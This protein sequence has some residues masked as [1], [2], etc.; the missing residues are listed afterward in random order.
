VLNIL[1][2]NIPEGIVNKDVIRKPE[3]L[4]KLSRFASR[5]NDQV[6]TGEL[7]QQA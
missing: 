5:G 2:G 1:A 7:V 6:D 3:W 4:T